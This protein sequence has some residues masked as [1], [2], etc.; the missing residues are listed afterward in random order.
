MDVKAFSFPPSET[1][2]RLGYKKMGGIFKVGLHR[3][4]LPG[5]FDVRFSCTV[6]VQ[7]S[8]SHKKNIAFLSV[9]SNKNTKTRKFSPFDLGFPLVDGSFFLRQKPKEP[10]N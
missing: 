8:D 7:K 1:L 2:G 9:F 6:A 3:E 5:K 4:D 10:T